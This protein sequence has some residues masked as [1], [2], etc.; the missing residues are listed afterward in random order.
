MKSIQSINRVPA[1]HWYVDVQPYYENCLYDMCACSGDVSRC[2]CPMLGDYAMACAA[3]GQHV[4]WR[5]NVKECGQLLL[6]NS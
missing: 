3:S 4:Q 1:C 5:Y 2:L 6:Q